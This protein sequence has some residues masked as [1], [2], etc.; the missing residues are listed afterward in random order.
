LTAFL[1]SLEHHPCSVSLL[2]FEGPLDLLLHLVEQAKL[3]ITTVSLVEVTGQYLD[4]MRSGEQ[5]DHR[6]LADFVAIGARLIWLKSRALLPLPPPEPESVEEEPEDLVEMLREYQRFKD[7]AW[8]LRDREETG[9]RA[10]PRLAAPPDVPVP[11]GLSH[12]TLARLAGVVQ[13]ALARVTPRA[14]PEPLA[15]MRYT[16][17]DQLARIELALRL[18]GKINF[19]RLIAALRTREEIVTAFLAVLELIK[20]G[21]LT[22]L[23]QSA[24]GDIWLIRAESFDGSERG[25]SEPELAGVQ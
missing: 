8:L 17:R 11:P 7:A 23:Q 16:L 25:D 18:Q 5:I 10:F 12:V 19:N 21:G 3:D 15:R 14:E 1:P 6:A 20:S 4:F 2:V 24:F 22:A 13:K 9:V